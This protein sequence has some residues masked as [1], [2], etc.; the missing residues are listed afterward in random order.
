MGIPR[1]TPSSEADLTVRKRF[2]RSYVG[3]N[4]T[5]DLVIGVRNRGPDSAESVEVEDALLAESI[6]PDPH[7]STAIV[8]NSIGEYHATNAT[9]TIEQLKPGATARLKIR[10]YQRLNDTFSPSNQGVWRSRITERP[11]RST[12]NETH[13]RLY[14]RVNN[15]ARVGAYS[16]DPKIENNR[17]W[18]AYNTTLTVLRPPPRERTDYDQNDDAQNTPVSPRTG[19]SNGDGNGSGGQE[20]GSNRK[21]GD[22]NSGEEPGDSGP[23]TTDGDGSG[24]SNSGEQDKTGEDEPGDSGG[25]ISGGTSWAPEGSDGVVITRKG[26]V[27]PGGEVTFGVTKDGRPIDGAVL[28]SEGTRLGKTG[29]EGTCDVIVPFDGSLNLSKGAISVD[30]PS[31]EQPREKPS[32]GES[33]SRTRNENSSIANQTE[34]KTPS[35]PPLNLSIH[36]R[37]IPGTMVTVVATRAETPVSGVY[38]YQNRTLV[39][40]TDANGSVNITIP[41]APRFSVWASEHG[42]N[43]SDTDN[44]NEGD[45]RDG[46][47]GPVVA[48]PGPI[49]GTPGAFTNI[50][51]AIPPPKLESSPNKANERKHAGPITA[52]IPDDA[53]ILNVSADTNLR[54]DTRG[55]AVPGSNLSVRVQIQGSPISNASVRLDGRTAGRTDRTG[56]LNVT[57]PF[58]RS[59]EIAANRGGI[60]G[61]RTV[62]TSG[63]LT[64]AV[65]SRPLPLASVP[66]EVTIDG[67]P[68]EGASVGLND[69]A[70]GRTSDTG[71]L[72]ARFP[73]ANTVTITAVRGELSTRTTRSGI[74][75]SIL[76]WIFAMTI[77]PPLLYRYGNLIRH[78][79]E[80]LTRPVVLRVQRFRHV[81]ATRA[82]A[83][84]PLGSVLGLLPWHPFEV[85]P[86]SGS[87]PAASGP[88]TGF[89]EGHS[90]DEVDWAWQSLLWHVPAEIDRSDTPQEVRE[91]ALEAGVSP[92]L[93][94]PI[95]TLLQQVRY[96]DL[97]LDRDL[98]N[99]AEEAAREIGRRESFGV[100]T[101]ATRDINTALGRDP[102]S[103]PE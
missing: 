80:T 88:M 5:V 36:G 84:G 7:F 64:I 19:G 99:A 59:V 95:V 77:L 2:N 52:E 92:D 81:V 56:E 30:L 27:V 23:G 37:P 22:D 15:S 47:D 67:E 89:S 33:E 79:I 55:R 60:S 38:I 46:F 41:F 32:G 53:T 49:T 14:Y 3:A 98:R 45:E 10:I 100:E 65:E 70:A 96:G 85:E 97:E 69:E 61:T 86:L 103:D 76:P 25:A 75:T 72:K 102:G 94:D 9:W 51:A 31:D 35:Q 91:K 87:H 66:L 26:Q 1:G 101:N 21:A 78:R 40:R 6:H 34:Q 4:E 24:G 12:R 20:S 62:N 39:G 42:A 18:D 48:R 17:D 43:L 83:G 82:A 71:K 74:L 58:N 29:E 16:R 63:N 8:N 90:H 73:L 44:R 68:V 13:R 57:V 28:R 50:V 11:P 54:I 93:A